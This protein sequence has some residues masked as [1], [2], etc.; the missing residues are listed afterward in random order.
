M[1][2]VYE[3]TASREVIKEAWNKAIRHLEK[4]LG[5]QYDYNCTDDALPKFFDKVEQDITFKMKCPV[6][7]NVDGEGNFSYSTLE[8]GVMIC[9]DCYSEEQN[10]QEIN[11]L[12]VCRIVLG[13][14]G[15]FNL[16]DHPQISIPILIVGFVLCFIEE[17]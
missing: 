7:H 6:C 16:F 4:K 11:M 3:F 8:K 14:V 15:G 1:T 5:D 17:K 10:K 2:Q 13:L 12:H 9:Y